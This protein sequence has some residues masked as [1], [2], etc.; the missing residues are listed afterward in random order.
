MANM[1]AM[2]ASDTRAPAEPTSYQ[3]LLSEVTSP[4]KEIAGLDD[5]S[6]RTGI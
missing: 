4:P 1:S 2:A 5:S 6:P 3:G